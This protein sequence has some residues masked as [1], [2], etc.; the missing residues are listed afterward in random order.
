MTWRSRRGDDFTC[1]RSGIGL[2]AEEMFFPFFGFFLFVFVFNHTFSY[3]LAG[4]NLFTLLP[5][6]TSSRGVAI[7]EFLVPI[8]KAYN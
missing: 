2:P 5:F 8:L 7:N 6:F 4:F 1:R 3:L